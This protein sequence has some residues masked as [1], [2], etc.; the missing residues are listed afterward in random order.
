MSPRKPYPATNMVG[1]KRTRRKPQAGDVFVVQ[2]PGST[3]VTGRVVHCKS[4]VM[5]LDSDGRGSSLVYFYVTT[6]SD[7]SSIRAPLAPVLLI[8]PQITNDMGWT[9]GY[10]R[11]LFNSPMRKEELLPRHVFLDIVRSVD[12]DLNTLPKEDPRSVF[13]DEYGHRIERPRTQEEYRMCGYGGL[14]SYRYIDDR[15][16]EALNL[17]PAP[18]DPR[19]TV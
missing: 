19:D 11:F 10:F 14:V 1:G 18:L 9:R 5:G 6:T 2:M 4:A 16:S 15:L 8:P 7:P 12:K 3:F 17:P 13:E